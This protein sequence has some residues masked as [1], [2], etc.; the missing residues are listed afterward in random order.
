[1]SP[2]NCVELCC[3]FAHSSTGSLLVRMLP[4][5]RL[6]GVVHVVLQLPRGLRCCFVER[7]GCL[8]LMGLVSCWLDV[9][10]RDAP[11]TTPHV[12]C[13]WRWCCTGTLTSPDSSLLC[14][15]SRA[16][17]CFFECH[18]RDSRTQSACTCCYNR[19]LAVVT[20]VFGSAPAPLLVGA[21][22]QAGMSCELLW[23]SQRSACLLI[24]CASCALPYGPTRREPLSSAC[25]A[26][27]YQPT[28]PS[29]CPTF[30]VR[31]W[32]PPSSC[33]VSSFQQLW[34]ALIRKHCCT[35]RKHCCTMQLVDA[36]HAL[37]GAPTASCRPGLL[38]VLA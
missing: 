6:S 8:R 26:L 1:M 3:L 29:T 10:C 33:R 36:W 24:L 11:S 16:C 18:G 2:H 7:C 12:P 31:A 35:I 5:V 19:C 27:C 15:S 32:V 30:P 4:K 23:H 25:L 28:P 13:G 22:P 14:Q 17:C 34:E 9:R 20:G 37:E 38:P 21:W